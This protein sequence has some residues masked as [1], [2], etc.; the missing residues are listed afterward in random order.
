S[1]LRPVAVGVLDQSVAGVVE[2][3]EHLLLGWP[4]FGVRH[5]LHHRVEVLQIGVAEI[6]DIGAMIKIDRLGR[7][8]LA[9]QINVVRARAAKSSTSAATTDRAEIEDMEWTLGG[10]RTQRVQS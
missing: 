7:Q 1:V 8:S 4:D 3:V 10:V 6:G 5:D 9:G 2:T